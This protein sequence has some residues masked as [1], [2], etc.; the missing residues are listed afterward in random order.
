MRVSFRKAGSNQDAP[1]FESAK[2]MNTVA[3]PRAESVRHERPKVLV[4]DDHPLFRRGIIAIIEEQPG[5]ALCCEAGSVEA[6]L[7][8]VRAKHP[9]V[10]VVDV[11]LPGPSGL[12][13]VQRLRTEDPALQVL[14]MSMHDELFYA[15]RALRCGAKGYLLKSEAAENLVTAL[16]QVIAG[17][18][19]ISPAFRE[20]LA[21]AGM[22]AS[23]NPARCPVDNLSPREREVFQLFGCGFRAQRVADELKLSVKTI[24]THRMHIQDKL[25]GCDAVGFMRKA[26]DWLTLHQDHGDYAFQPL[27]DS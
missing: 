6:A 12:D 24:E 13:F 16:S 10:A 18:V 8:E 4:V 1:L 2:R 27:T 19:Y 5:F 23:G 7:Q 26:T 25:G 14:V 17:G 22:D 15:V 11:S 21:F 20:R 3:E 9:D